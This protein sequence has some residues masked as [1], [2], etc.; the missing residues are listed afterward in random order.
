MD[1]LGIY[2]V[3]AGLLQR[4]NDKGGLAA[5]ADAAHVK[6][7][8][9]QNALEHGGVAQVAVSKNDHVVLLANAHVV[10]DVLKRA[11]GHGTCLRKETRLADAGAVVDHMDHKANGSQDRHQCLPHVAAA[12]DV[13]NGLG[14]NRF[15][16]AARSLVPGGALGRAIAA[17]RPG[18]A[19]GVAP[20]LDQPRPFAAFAHADKV[21]NDAQVIPGHKAD[22]QKSVAAASHR[23]LLVRHP[24]QARKAQVSSVAGV[25]GI[26]ALRGLKHLAHSLLR[27][28][29]DVA[30]ANGPNKAAVGE[31][32]HAGTLA[33]GHRSPGIQNGGQ[34]HG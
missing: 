3:D 33:P 4:V 10:V 22:G 27:D 5:A 16:V 11:A 6:G 13:A 26:A 25:A 31:K 7:V 24:F 9:R 19:L 34:C 12:K 14:G 8:A 17:H 18:G 32:P 29:L 15:L 20:V 2:S 30:A 21:F 28:A 1:A 23:V